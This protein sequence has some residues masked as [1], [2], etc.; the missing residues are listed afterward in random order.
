MVIAIVAEAWESASEQTSKNYWLYRL[1]KISEVRSLG[2][3]G[4]TRILYWLDLIG[5]IDKIP[6]VRVED[7]V[8]WHVEE[9]FTKVKDKSMYDRPHDYSPL[10]AAAEYRRSAADVVL[11]SQRSFFMGS[12]SGCQTLYRLP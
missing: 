1:N 4:L 9:P 5:W 12:V 11:E 3:W 8:P 6:D 2:E 7:N 10:V